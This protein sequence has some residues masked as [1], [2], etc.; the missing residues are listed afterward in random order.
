MNLS[1]QRIRIS[2]LAQSAE[3]QPGHLA[4][5]EVLPH[6]GDEVDMAMTPPS[7]D[8]HKAFRELGWIDQPTLLIGSSLDTHPVPLGILS[9]EAA[10]YLCFADI[11]RKMVGL[12]GER[13]PN[14]LHEISVG[15]LTLCLLN[16]ILI[17]NRNPPLVLACASLIEDVEEEVSLSLEFRTRHQNNLRILDL[18]KIPEAPPRRTGGPAQKTEEIMGARLIRARLAFDTQGN[19]LANRLQRLDDLNTPSA[20]HA[21]E[22]EVDVLITPNPSRIIVWQRRF[23]GSPLAMAYLIE[24]IKS[25]RFRKERFLNRHTQ[26]IEVVL[27]HDKI[28]LY[29]ETS[30][31]Q[32]AYDLTFILRKKYLD[33]ENCV[34]VSLYQD[35]AT[36]L[37][38]LT[39]E[40]TIK[41]PKAAVV[42]FIIFKQQQSSA[43]SD[44]VVA[45]FKNLR[46]SEHPHLESAFRLFVET[47]NQGLKRG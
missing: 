22:G 43:P 30:F 28:I 39:T 18:W 16:G 21:Q 36:H 42:E 33:G 24:L 7:I 45:T 29:P 26:A 17:F 47:Y 15:R 2:I 23:L 37:W 1:E 6:I 8:V 35:P 32:A 10:D 4:L 9:R 41:Q 20:G 12:H 44:I 25:Q 13:D 38:S 40:A 19:L 5:A 34:S 27:A 3:H 31:A 14:N 11:H 46:T